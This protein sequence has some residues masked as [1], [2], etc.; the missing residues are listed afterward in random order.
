M[1]VMP[2]CKRKENEEEYR[3]CPFSYSEHSGRYL[4]NAVGCRKF[5]GCAGERQRGS[6]KGAEKMREKFFLNELEQ[7]QT[8]EVNK[9]LSEPEMKRRFHDIGLIC[10]TKVT[11]V[12]RGPFGDPKAYEIR[13]AVV[14]I[15]NSDAKQ[16]EI[17][18]EKFPEK[19][20]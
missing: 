11:C 19:G 6:G 18:S 20:V 9:I 16:I 2:A 1:T 17:W 14:A 12:G 5:F 3:N 8:G 10:G 13:G 7:N 15:R 4:Q